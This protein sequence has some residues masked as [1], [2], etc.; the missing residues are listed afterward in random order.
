MHNHIIGIAGYMGSGKTTFSTLLAKRTGYQLVSGDL[1][2]KR[3]MVGNPVVSTSLATA[4]GSEIFLNGELSFSKLGSIVFENSEKLHIL[5]RIVHPLLLD[6]LRNMIFTHSSKKL[7]ID[8]ALLPMWGI[9]DWFDDRVWIDA[10]GAIRA[11]RILRKGQV[12][13][14]AVVRARMLLQEQL[15]LP[16]L[17][18]NWT[19]IQNGGDVATL[20]ESVTAFATSFVEKTT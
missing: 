6:S 16:P 18:A 13:D 8:A 12:I 9:E 17:K 15:L 1:E 3:V 2:A 5:N 14:P 7:I 11:A 10:P 4:F 19:Y 20:E